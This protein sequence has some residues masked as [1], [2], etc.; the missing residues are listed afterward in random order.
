MAAD[1]THLEK[2]RELTAKLP[3]LETM[4]VQK[5]PGCV[6]Y[7][8]EHGT[9]HGVCLFND[10]QIA[11][12]QGNVTGGSVFPWHA[13][14]TCVEIIIVYAGRMICTNRIRGPVELSAGD[15]VFCPRGVEHMHEFLEDTSL[16]AI[17]IPADPSYPKPPEV[18]R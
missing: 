14:D 15:S 16:I 3:P 13:H 5:G 11:V 9:C 1:D 10:G 7:K 4:T 18:P 6:E 17:T 12:Q 8:V 2:L